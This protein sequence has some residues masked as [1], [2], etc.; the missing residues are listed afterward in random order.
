MIWYGAYLISMGRV[1]AANPRAGG[2]NPP[3]GTTEI[4]KNFLN[5]V[6]L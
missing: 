4:L 1:V 2:S 3:P 6:P 5:V